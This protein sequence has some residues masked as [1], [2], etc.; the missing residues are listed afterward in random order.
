[1]F[2]V[3]PEKYRPLMQR[4]FISKISDALDSLGMRLVS[5]SI[6]V[7]PVGKEVFLRFHLR[8]IQTSLA[9]SID[10]EPTVKGLIEKLVMEANESLGRVYG[11]T[12]IIED[13]SIEQELPKDHESLQD[14]PKLVLDVPL[15]L[16]GP[17]RRIGKGLVI[18]LREWGIAA[19]S[20]VLGVDPSGLNR[21]SLVV[22]LREPM[23]REEKASLVKALREKLAGYIKLL[24]KKPMQTSVKIID[25]SDKVVAKVMKKTKLMEKEVENI[26]GNEDVRAIMK[27]LGKL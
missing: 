5:S 11:V 14:Q 13:V 26:I 19:A 9:G 24:I 22:K 3:I 10:V 16:E 6:Y 20:I 18:S 1:M 17:F 15:E 27:A 2:E 8:V 25:P 21:V 23:G 12:F 7:N 4:L